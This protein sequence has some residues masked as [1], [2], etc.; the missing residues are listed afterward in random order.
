MV[1]HPPGPETRKVLTALGGDHPMLPADL[2]ADRAAD[3]HRRLAGHL[4][5]AGVEVLQFREL[6]DAAIEEARMAGA[7]ADWLTRCAPALLGRADELTSAHLIGAEDDIVYNRR[8]DGSFA[9]LAS[10]MKWLLF[11]RDLAVMT[12]AGVVLSAFAN[13]DRAFEADLA[14][15]CFR[16]APALRDIPIAFDAR[17]EGVHLQ[18]G[19]AVVLDPATLL[20][21]VGNLTEP[22]AAR[23]LARR[24]HMDVIAVRLPGY[25]F[26]PGRAYDQWTGF[27][28]LCLHLDSILGL[29]DDRIA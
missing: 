24:L 5:R 14:G 8:A 22:D 6:L 7:L 13:R 19:D 15:L 29:V 11:V 25:G 23:C 10:P 26:A 20:L 17:V 28:T 2:L 27:R 12:P 9:P 1:V 16:W 3:H 18:G 21:G 4:A